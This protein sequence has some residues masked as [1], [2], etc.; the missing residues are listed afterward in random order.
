M[1]FTVYSKCGHEYG[2]IIEEEER[3]KILK[4]LRKYIFMPEENINQENIDQI[5]N[6]LIEEINQ[7]ELMSEKHKKRCRVLNYIDHSLTVISTITLCVSISAVAS[8]VGIPI[9]I[10]SSAIGLQI[11]AITARIKKYKCIIKNKKEKA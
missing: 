6:N 11:C 4:I 3:I 9:G 2:K 10:T 8:L 5:E 7:N 1:F